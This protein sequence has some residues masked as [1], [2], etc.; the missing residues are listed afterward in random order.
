M[1]QL[2]ASFEVAVFTGVPLVEAIT[3]MVHVAVVTPLYTVSTKGTVTG[4][5]VVFPMRTIWE[6]LVGTLPNVGLSSA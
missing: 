4:P 5:P 2:G 1:T 3:E 6:P